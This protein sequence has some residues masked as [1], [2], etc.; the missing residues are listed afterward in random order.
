MFKSTI[1]FVFSMVCSMSLLWAQIPMPPA[2]AVVKAD[3][4]P[5]LLNLSELV[6]KI[7]YPE[8]AQKA[9]AEGTVILRVLFDEKGNYLK[10][11]VKTEGHPLLLKAVEKDIKLIK[12][13]PLTFNKKP[14]Q[15][16]MNVPFSF[17]L[18]GIDKIECINFEEVR[19]KIGYP[20]KAKKQGITGQVLV[21]I[22]ADEKGNVIDYMV[23]KS[24]HKLLTQAVEA[25]IKELKFKP[26]TKNGVPARINTSM[27][28]EF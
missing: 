28:F 19:E 25:H 18:K 26:M 9:K 11:E 7:G 24:D 17:K 14:I 22:K 2:D 6:N 27:I 21:S 16:S 20:E 5:E 1:I 23:A 4:P 12:A 8:E 3:K 10:H 15:F 13:K